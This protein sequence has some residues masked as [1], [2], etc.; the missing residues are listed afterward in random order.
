VAKNATGNTTLPAGIINF[1]STDESVVFQD[2]MTATPSNGAADGVPVFSSSGMNI[3]AGGWTF[4][5]SGETG[6]SGLDKAGQFSFEVESIGISDDAA[7]TADGIGAGGRDVTST[8][9]LMSWANANSTGASP[10]GRM[11]MASA[12]ALTTQLSAVSPGNGSRGART[13]NYGADTYKKVTISWIGDSF[14]I[15]YDGALFEAA[16]TGG[17]PGT[18][19]FKFIFFGTNRGGTTYNF[20]DY[21]VK[22]FII[23]HRP[24]MAPVH[25]SLSR[26]SLMGD[27]FMNQSNEDADDQTRGYEH[28]FTLQCAAYLR[29]RGLG[30]NF[31]NN[32]VSGALIKAAA[33]S[34]ISDQVATT[35]ADNPRT[36]VI[37]GGTNDAI[38]SSGYSESTFDTD[39]KSYLTSLL[40][41]GTGIDKVFV[42]TVPSLKGVVAT[43]DATR[44]SQ[45]ASVNS[46]ISGLPAWWDA[47]N[48]SD[49]GRVVVY[50]LFTKTGGESASDGMI[51]GLWNA[52]FTNY[53]NDVHLSSQGRR[54]FGR[55][56]GEAIYN[57]L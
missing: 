29:E 55:L 49:T 22:N 34:T 43:Y 28:Q 20:G 1:G 51:A 16:K 33:G 9:Y 46:V 18:D 39:Y 44:I 6:Y 52:S 11:Y 50:D 42:G 45:T 19:I 27:S 30:I 32:G 8:L 41:A 3:N 2:A 54:V 37:Q 35:L 21:N 5:L 7:R 36:V 4:D 40:A 10:W 23:S 56:V 53:Q 47:A 31:S 15:Y 26:V 13:T 38:A 57:N 12:N 14:T 17:F 24:V 48:P 25:P